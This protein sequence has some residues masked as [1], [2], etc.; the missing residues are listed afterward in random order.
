MEVF[1]H[2]H[3]HHHHHIFKACGP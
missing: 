1:I 2:H 3:H